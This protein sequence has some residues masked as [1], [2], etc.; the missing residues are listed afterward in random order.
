MHISV[1]VYNAFRSQVAACR[2]LASPF[3]ADVLQILLERLE[4]GNAVAA[5]IMGWQGDPWADAL[6]LRL[7]GALHA[8]A[9]S[10]AAP[11]LADCYPGGARAGDLAA[12]RSAIGRVIDQEQAHLAGYL[13][14]PPQTN[15]TLRSAVL[16]GGF[17]TIADEF[18]LPL[19]L[20]EIG[21]SAG[22][23]MIWDQYRYRLGS[24]LFGPASSPVLL[25]AAWRGP[26]PE[27]LMP[28]VISRAACDQAPV[29]IQDPAQQ[30]RLRSYIWADQSPRLARLEGAIALALAAGV[31]VD[32]ADAAAW[33]AH[34]LAQPVTDAV[35]VI[36]HSV[37]WQYLPAATQQKLRDLMHQA[38]QRAPVAWLRFEPDATSS[39]FELRLT[40][41]RKGIGQERLLATAHP[42][43]ATISWLDSSTVTQ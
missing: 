12:L 5:P 2:Q 25:E 35:T 23:N 13:A 37:M 42:H 26:L 3:T 24:T 19:R 11:Y 41:W 34:H 6:P 36:Y 14:H 8:L 10:K 40:L 28:Q 27:L 43:G 18:S 29:D 38:G 9:L 39:A 4:A 7:A 22:L 33:L 21:A 1:A 32:R 15:E 30:L 16:L 17:M 20:L 31:T